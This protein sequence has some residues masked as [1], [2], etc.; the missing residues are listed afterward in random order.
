MK[1]VRDVAWLT[2]LFCGEDRARDRDRKLTLFAAMTE[3][4]EERQGSS[5][6]VEED[7]TDVTPLIDIYGSRSQLVYRV[8]R[9]L[10]E[11]PSCLILQLANFG[12]NCF[13]GPV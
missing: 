5:S 11:I 1:P 2:K 4:L 8:I 3:P 12:A 10:H 9:R 13:I 6:L 7:V